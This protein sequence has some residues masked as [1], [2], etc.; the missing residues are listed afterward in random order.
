MLSD[1]L[2]AINKRVVPVP[3]AALS[4]LATYFCV[5]VLIFHHARPIPT[6]GDSPAP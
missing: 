6:C 4:I 1:L 5:Q 2:I 3:L